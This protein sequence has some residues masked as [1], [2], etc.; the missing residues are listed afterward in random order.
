MIAILGLVFG[1]LT[2]VLLSIFALPLSWLVG[3][4]VP[5]FLINLFWYGFN[6]LASSN[7]IG[8]SFANGQVSSNSLT[9]ING[10]TFN[11]N[12]NF[13]FNTNLTLKVYS[14]VCL[15]SVFIIIFSVA[16]A[17]SRRIFA[18]YNLGETNLSPSLEYIL[19]FFLSIILVPLIFLFLNFF[20]SLMLLIVIYGVLNTES[21]KHISPEDV[22]NFFSKFTNGVDP[23]WVSNYTN[24]INDLF[25]KA[26]NDDNLRSQLNSILSLANGTGV[27][28]GLGFNFLT[29]DVVDFFKNN[30][31]S[32]DREIISKLNK[33]YNEL[34]QIQQNITQSQALLNNL[35]SRYGPDYQISTIGSDSFN[36]IKNFYNDI[37]GINNISGHI[38]L[39]DVVNI[40]SNQQLF[41]LIIPIYQVVSGQNDTNWRNVFIQDWANI[42]GV[43]PWVRL[44]S[45]IIIATTL[46]TFMLKFVVNIAL[47]LFWIIGLLV[48]APFSIAFGS[49]DHGYR[50]RL[51]FN[52]VVKAFFSL[53]VIY[54]STEFFILITASIIAPIIQYNNSFGNDQIWQIGVIIPIIIASVIG[55]DVFVKYINEILALG[56]VLKTNRSSTSTSKSGKL[57][58]FSSPNANNSSA[59]EYKSN[60]IGFAN[61]LGQNTGQ[62]FKAYKSGR[63]SLSKLK[64]NRFKNRNFG[65]NSFKK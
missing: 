34:V 58:N 54:F 26:T 55:I 50:L 61:R 8:L 27:N 51:W 32:T 4:V 52:E 14:V 48:I 44:S 21:I 62:S 20:I 16:V 45:G 9:A 5:F 43:E 18:K 65:S 36:N 25:I 11:L 7:L 47:R 39:N 28:D 19:Y 17:Y 12:F 31:A 1:V 57:F 63:N 10:T 37:L 15:I 35:I 49:I 56:R 24:S 2:T 22:D 13:D 40:N 38:S 30:Y 23:I 53:F 59:N 3:V 33:L 6:I 29:S 60:S 42:F 46:L 64:S 41:P